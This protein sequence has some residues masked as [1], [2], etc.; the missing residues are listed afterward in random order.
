MFG[1]FASITIGMIFFNFGIVKKN[2]QLSIVALLVTFAGNSHAFESKVCST[3]LA[4]LEDLKSWKRPLPSAEWEALSEV[5]NHSKQNNVPNWYFSHVL[6]SAKDSKLSVMRNAGEVNKLIK[7]KIGFNRLYRIKKLY[8]SLLSSKELTSE[9]TRNL[10]RSSLVKENYLSNPVKLDWIMD[11]K[12]SQEANPESLFDRMYAEIA[13]Q[14]AAEN[15]GEKGIQSLFSEMHKLRESGLVNSEIGMGI[16]YNSFLIKMGYMPSLHGVSAA[17]DIG[18]FEREMRSGLIMGQLLSEDLIARSSLGIRTNASPV[19]FLEHIPEKIKIH[20]SK[21]SL[22][23]TEIDF[24]AL[25]FINYLSKNGLEP[26]LETIEKHTLDYSKSIRKWS[27]DFLGDTVS[28]KKDIF[29]LNRISEDFQKSFFDVSA[30]DHDSWKKKMDLFYRPKDLLYRGQYAKKY[31]S[32]EQVLEYFLDISKEVVSMRSKV[33]AGI[34]N[35]PFLTRDFQQFNSLFEADPGQLLK[36][37]YDHMTEGETY[38]SSPFASASLRIEVANRFS[39]GFMRTREEIVGLKSQIILSFYRRNGF[40]EIELNRLNSMLK[41]NTSSLEF[42][43]QF[44][45]QSEVLVVGGVEPDAVAGVK[46][47]DVEGGEVASNTNQNIL[48]NAT[49]LRER[50][51]NRDLSDPS[52]I[53]V[54]ETEGGHQSV[55]KYRLSKNRFGFFNFELEK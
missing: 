11:N 27:I 12:L 32:D 10:I 49:V 39:Q 1:F 21:S 30:H 16:V 15:N 47:V 52:L 42:K 4:G 50:S 41:A 44:A 37:A 7:N 22:G 55:R 38:L 3:Y 45:R 23:D 25:S 9:E 46:I 26:T 2:T 13:L 8:A 6:V 29:V 51:F 33:G 18:I 54:I 48:A 19:L 24:D 36:L 35:R 53:T 34:I 40:G 17:P 5:L 14:L 43:T 28:T 20:S 31:L